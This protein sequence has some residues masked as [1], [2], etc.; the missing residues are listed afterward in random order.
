MYSRNVVV[1]P[2]SGCVIC[3]G[4]SPSLSPYR[5]GLLDD[6]VFVRA[7][8]SG[9]L[10]AAVRAVYKWGVRHLVRLGESPLRAYEEHRKTYFSKRYVVCCLWFLLLLLL[11]LLL[12]FLAL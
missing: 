3:H 11:L 12:L 5:H 8:Y 9:L 1:N 4:T 10:T 2:I 6:S 7:G